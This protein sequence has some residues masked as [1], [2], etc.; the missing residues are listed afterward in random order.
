MIIE[1][2]LFGLIGG[3]VAAAVAAY[4]QEIKTWAI[5]IYNQLPSPIKQAVQDVAAYLQKIGR[6]VKS[7]ANYYWFKSE[8][9]TWQ[10]TTVTREMDYN[11]IPE[12]IREK[13]NNQ[14]KIELELKNT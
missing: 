5:G 6:S 2:L 7:I 4:W 14:N 8:T 12:E 3:G 13:L 1:L 10:E 11:E 9:K